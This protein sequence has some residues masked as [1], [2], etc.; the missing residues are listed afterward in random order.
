TFQFSNKMF[1][2]SNCRFVNFLF[3]A[4]YSCERVFSIDL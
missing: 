1:C 3:I 2:V 4:Y